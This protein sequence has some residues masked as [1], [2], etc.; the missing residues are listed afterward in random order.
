[1][2][3]EFDS[4]AGKE[5]VVLTDTITEPRVIEFVWEKSLIKKSKQKDRIIVFGHHT[6][7]KSNQISG[8]GNQI[9]L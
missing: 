7:I 9:Q 5:R 2:S 6:I 1:M 4:K 3:K 8:K